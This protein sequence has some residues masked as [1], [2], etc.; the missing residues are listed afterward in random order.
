MKP[1]IQLVGAMA[2]CC[3]VASCAPQAQPVQIWEGTG[4]I[5]LREQAYRLTFTVNDSTHELKGQLQNRSSGDTFLVTGTYL[6]VV[7]GAEVTAQ[8]TAGGGATLNASLLGFGI[9][10]V[11]LKSDALL[12]GQIKGEVFSGALRVN[13]LAYPLALTRR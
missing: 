8:V 3:V 12:T 1:A 5:A 10:G 4:R 7:G 6:P 9:S 11:S 2:L 13:G